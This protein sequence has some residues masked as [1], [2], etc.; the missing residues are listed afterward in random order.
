VDEVVVLLGQVKGEHG[1]IDGLLHR[2]GREHDGA[3]ITVPGGAG[4][5]EVVALGR[6]DIAEAGPA[7][8]DVHDHAGDVRAGDVRKPLLHQADA[9]AGRRGHH[10][11]TGA[12]SAVNHV[13]GGNFA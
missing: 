3:V 7:A 10:T 2:G 4:H 5:L 11:N 1:E 6:E 9:G 13:D 8:H 12:R